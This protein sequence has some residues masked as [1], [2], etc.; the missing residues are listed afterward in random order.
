MKAVVAGATGFIGHTL[1]EFLIAQGYETVV[2]TRRPA[3]NT[4]SRTL[5]VKWDGQTTG[6]WVRQIGSADA[7]INLAGENIAEGRW[8][9][10]RK[11]KIIESRL[12]T[13]RTL[14]NAIAASGR[15][16]GVFVNASAV[17]YYG[18]VPT[19]DVT[20]DHPAG[21]GFLAETCVRW[22]AEA[23]KAAGSGVRVVLPRIGIVLGENGG[24]LA[25]M[26]PPFKHFLGGPL[27]SGRQWF[28]WI[29]V[30][31]V[32][33]SILHAMEDVTVSG[34]FN[35][36]AP[37]P[38]SMK[39]FCTT[40]ARVLSRP[41]LAKVPAAVLKILMGEMAEMILGGQKAIPEKILLRGYAFRYPELE[42]ALRVILGESE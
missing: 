34:P 33:G 13:A 15:K 5:Q 3:A 18:N 20:E 6:E 23:M 29:H 27:G 12:S 10:A 38:V 40:L 30:E 21:K 17:G 41:C 8:T 22:E 26:V 36:S 9:P 11:K 1:L 4:G 39:E 32:A 37:N 7:V 19:G 31:D 25:K 14:V 16:P 24:A 42:P 2:L 28:P 35:A